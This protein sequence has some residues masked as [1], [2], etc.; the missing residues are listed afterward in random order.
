MLIIIHGWSDNAASFTTLAKRL[1]RP[2][3]DGIGADIRQINLGDYVSLDDQVGFDDLVE[4]MQKA[5]QDQSLP[6]LP[7]QVDVIVHS[8]GGLVIRH[9]LSRYYSPDTT[10]IKRL[11]MLAPANFGSPLAHTGR[12]MM[13]RAIK[14]WKGTRL[15]ETGTRILKGLEIASPY[16]WQL[17]EKDLL[18]DQS[19]YGPGRILCTVLVGNTGYTGISALANRP[20]TDGTVRVSSANLNA[21]SMELD[22]TDPLASITPQNIRQ[23]N[24]TAFG[25]ADREDH[26]SI[27][28][29]A[30]GP[31]RKETWELI[32]TALQ[33]DDAGF[34]SWQQQLA[35]HS[36]SVTLKAEK[37]RG[38][39]TNSYMNA[40]IRVV[41]NYGA[42]VSDYVIELYANDDMGQRN[43]NR[44]QRLQELA[45]NDVHAWSD[46]KSYRSFLI[47]CTE[48]YKILGR[49]EDRLHISITASPELRSGLVGYNTYTDE[50]IGSLTL[51]QQQL[52]AL[53]QPHRTLLL[54]IRLKRYQRDGVFRFKLVSPP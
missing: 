13:G 21:T 19:F 18:C 2:E 52:K 50:D 32:R 54:T 51:D 31:H 1:A 9:W 23:Q 43:R 3:P 7:R 37:R 24:A 25:I 30:G 20:G 53:F 36:Q 29:K 12:S 26:S 15:F 46:D 28:A 49:A 34:P 5:W 42:G 40:V 8:T 10:P 22:F 4:A 6:T 48:L 16:S 38:L 47:N 44:T 39:H 45:I 14:G 27:A 35:Q 11:L 33:I 17:A 41:D